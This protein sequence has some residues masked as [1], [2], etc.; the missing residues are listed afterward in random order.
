MNIS[1]RLNASLNGTAVTV[2]IILPS[3]NQSEQVIDL[4]NYFSSS[5]TMLGIYTIS[6]HSRDYTI[7]EG[8]RK[9]GS[10]L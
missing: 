6:G 8:S 4:L 9:L 10:R 5:I 3:A 1:L 2:E 7:I